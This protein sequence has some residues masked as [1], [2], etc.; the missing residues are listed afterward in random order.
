MPSSNA[1]LNGVVQ[2]FSLKRNLKAL[3]VRPSENFATIDGIR[4]ISILWLIVFHVFFLMRLYID[5][6]ALTVLIQTTPWYM[7]WVWNADK[8]VD[9]FFV[10]SGFLISHLLFK[11]YQNKQTIN[12]KRFYWRRFLRLTPVYWFALLLCFLFSDRNTDM[13]WANV[14]YLNN[15]IPVERMPMEWTWSLAVE[16]Q[17]YIVFPLFLVFIFF[18]STRQWQWLVGLLLLSVLIRLL[19]AFSYESIWHGNFADLLNPSSGLSDYINGMY[20]NLYTRF[21][22]LACGVL[23]SYAY[24]YKGDSLAK[25]L[26]GKIGLLLT[27]ASFAVFIFLSFLP[28][29]NPDIVWP[30]YFELAYIIFNRLLFGLAAAWLVLV[31]LHP[32]LFGILFKSFLALRLWYPI[33]QLSYS[34][35]LFHI[36]V[37][38]FVMFNVSANLEARDIAMDSLTFWQVTSVV[39]VVFPLSMLFSI[40]TYLLIEKPF[41]NLRGIRVK[42]AAKSHEKPV[43]AL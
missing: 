37:I 27:C 41:M 25:L 1:T 22:P 33:A 38:I 12:L 40:F 10:I 9:A 16:E 24:F 20:V 6:E 39:S 19:V 32:G 34:M 42:Q 29:L 5:A 36:M 30:S 28:I 26:N 18:K 11:E 21:A 17:F 7:Q 15:F 35:Y 23:A 31:S 4:A 3:F 43:A 13:L 8:A 2:A 14:F